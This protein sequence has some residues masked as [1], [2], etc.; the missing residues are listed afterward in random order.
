VEQQFGK[1]TERVAQFVQSVEKK[2][3]MGVPYARGAEILA[4]HKSE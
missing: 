1:D 4:A 2:K 3:I